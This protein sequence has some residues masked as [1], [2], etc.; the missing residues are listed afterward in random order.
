MVWYDSSDLIDW[1]IGCMYARAEL[2]WIRTTTSSRVNLED[3]WID[4]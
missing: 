3:R 4:R 1:F 2:N